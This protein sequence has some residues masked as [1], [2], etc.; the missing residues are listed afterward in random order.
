MN[1]GGRCCH[2]SWLQWS[3]QTPRWSGKNPE[4]RR[5]KLPQ[6][7]LFLMS[8][9][10]SKAAGLTLHHHLFIS[11]SANSVITAKKK[12]SLEKTG[13]QIDPYS[14]VGKRHFFLIIS[15][16]PNPDR[17]HGNLFGWLVCSVL[18][19]PP[20][21]N[22]H[23]CTSSLGHYHRTSENG[24]NPW[25]FI[26]LIRAE[27]P[28]HSPGGKVMASKGCTSPGAN[29]KPQ[30]FLWDKHNRS[31]IRLVLRTPTPSCIFLLRSSQLLG[32]LKIII[33]WQHLSS[34]ELEETSGWKIQNT[35]AANW[36][37]AG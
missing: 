37:I 1:G 29:K 28:P 31:S 9:H 26:Y 32:D 23:A 13:S 8:V 15:N 27:C 33:Y 24:W 20:W 21:A 11:T 14:H 5:L 30:T 36:T 22:K 17:L 3:G 16:I 19:Q 2:L 18:W 4:E 12:I 34:P 7:G 35:S 10:V 25:L 6:P